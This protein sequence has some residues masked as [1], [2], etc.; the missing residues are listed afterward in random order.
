VALIAVL[1][2]PPSGEVQR[3]NLNA[4]RIFINKGG[5]LYQ[6]GTTTAIP[7]ISTSGTLSLNFGYTLS[8]GQVVLSITPSSTLTPTAIGIEYSI[9]LSNDKTI[10]K[11]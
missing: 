7:T 10:T 6:N 9:E 2:A 3:A 11:L 5:T 8:S 4:E 1:A